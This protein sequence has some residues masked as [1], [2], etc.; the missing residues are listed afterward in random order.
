MGCG[1]ST[2]TPVV[3]GNYRRPEKK[4]KPQQPEDEADVKVQYD[5]NDDTKIIEIGTTGLSFI[6]IAS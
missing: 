5:E 2:A 1:A 3:E 6:L 4:R